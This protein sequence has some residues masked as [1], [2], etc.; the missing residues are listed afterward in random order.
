M[1]LMRSIIF[2]ILCVFLT[3]NLSFCQEMTNEWKEFISDKGFKVYYK[4]TNCDPSIGYDTESILLSIQNTTSNKILV[5]WDMEIYYADK[6]ST[7][8]HG[9]EYKYRYILEPNQSLE[10]SCAIDADSRLK[11]FSKFIDPQYKLHQNKFTEFKFSNLK[12][13]VVEL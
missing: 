12:V 3:S 8:N 5:D 2:L 11:V 6:C 1:S 9:D 7:C 10:G 13:T 4:Y